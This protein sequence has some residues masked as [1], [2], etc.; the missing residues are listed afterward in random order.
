[1]CWLIAKTWE[2]FFAKHDQKKAVSWDCGGAKTVKITKLE[3]D[4]LPDYLPSNKYKDNKDNNSNINGTEVVWEAF[5]L[6]N[7]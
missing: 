3:I 7:D 4:G 1:M 2:E 5:D 6:K